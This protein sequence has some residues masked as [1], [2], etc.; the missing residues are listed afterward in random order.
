MKFS[1]SFA[2]PKVQVS[3]CKLA[4]G[5]GA[6]IAISFFSGERYEH[7]VDWSSYGPG[8]IHF[9]VC[10]ENGLVGTI[11]VM[12]ETSDEQQFF[13]FFQPHKSRNKETVQFLLLH[14][15]FDEGDSQSFVHQRN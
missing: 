13:P 5:F 2:D 4:N 11:E 3:F 10:D 8:F 14:P 6:R 12:A 7:D 15:Q 1:I 9:E